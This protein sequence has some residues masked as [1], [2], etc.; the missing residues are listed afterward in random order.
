MFTFTRLF[1]DS[2]GESHFDDLEIDLTSAEYTPGVPP[3]DL[4][5]TTSATQVR[6]LEAPSGWTS[7]WHT[8]SARTLFL[9]LTG[10]WEVTASDGET[11]RFSIGS[12]LLVEDTMG[13]GHLSTVTSVDGSL[14]VMIELARQNLEP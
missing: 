6:F 4:S 5:G 3:M 1:C 9:V 10:A 14:A 13:K 2:S 11:R 8:S 12:P 7:D